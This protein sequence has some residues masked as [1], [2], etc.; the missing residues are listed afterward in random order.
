LFLDAPALKKPTGRSDN[1]SG[2]SP[3][4]RISRR[5]PSAACV[6]AT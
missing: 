5:V 4:N 2:R 1:S 6:V 3:V